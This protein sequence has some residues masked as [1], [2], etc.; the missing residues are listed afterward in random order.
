MEQFGTRLEQVRA[1]LGRAIG[2]LPLVR[3][4]H[5]GHYRPSKW[6]KMAIF[7]PEAGL[8]TLNWSGSRLEHTR[9]MSWN[10]F[11]GQEWLSRGAIVPQNGLLWSVMAPLSSFWDIFGVIG[12]P[13]EHS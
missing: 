12:P 4:N 5:Y 6:T 3:N 9:A 13:N 7:V 8:V 2:T 11:T 1:D 10:H